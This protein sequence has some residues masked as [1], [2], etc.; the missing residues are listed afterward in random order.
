MRR[1]VKATWLAALVGVPLLAGWPGGL[2]A[3]VTVIESVVVHPPVRAPFQC[4]EHALGAEGHVPDALGSDCVVTRR[5]GGPKGNLN[6]MYSGDGTRNEDWYG[7]REPLLAPCDGVVTIVSLN[8]E[9]TV[10]GEFGE[11]RS[12]AMLF[13]CGAE[14]D[15]DA[16]QVAYIHVREVVVSEGDSV[17]AGQPVAR[18]GNNGSSYNPHVHIG[19]FRGELF[20]DDAVPL[21]IRMDLAAMGGVDRP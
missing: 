17:R 14:A 11:G 9:T 1:P 19:A 7:W 13:R 2:R 6:A 10:P 4:S 18:I 20:S 5:A 12:S 21:Q 8:P 16:V 15:P 3:Q